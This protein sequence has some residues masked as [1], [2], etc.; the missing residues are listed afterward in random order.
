MSLS[1]PLKSSLARLWRYG[2]RDSQEQSAE[3]YEH[4]SPMG[5]L[6]FLAGFG[7][8][9][10]A[11]L[12]PGLG[13]LAHDHEDACD[14][15]DHSEHG[16]DHDR[17]SPISGSSFTA[18]SSSASSPPSQPMK[19][20]PT[21]QPEAVPAGIEICGSPAC[22]ARQ[23]LPKVIALNSTVEAPSGMS[24]SGGRVGVVGMRIIVP[25]LAR[26][27]SRSLAAAR[28]SSPILASSLVM[29]EAISKRSLIAGDNASG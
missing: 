23:V 17:A 6:R 8:P 21:G 2:A 9:A 10:G 4:N 12:S 13:G 7:K 18:R 25:G 29:R 28:I 24:R 15:Q 20:R 5:D 19:E 16:Q 14:D 3:A 11:P 26:P 22:P 1:G 27:C